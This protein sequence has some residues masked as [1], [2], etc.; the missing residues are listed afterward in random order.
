M[1]SMNWIWNAA[2]IAALTVT[3]GCGP[4]DPAAGTDQHASSNAPANAPGGQQLDEHGHPV[5]SH[6]ELDE[7]GH[8]VGTH[9]EEKP[10]SGKPG[11]PTLPGDGP[12]TKLPA[13]K[14]HATPSGLT[15]GS[16]K[17][18][19]GEAAK[20]GQMVFVHYTGWTHSTK[21]KF[22]SS[23]DRGEPIDFPLGAG[24]VIQG[25]DEGVAGMKP[26]EQRQ[27]VI[28]ADLGYGAMGRGEDIPGGATLIFD[29]EL[30][31]AQ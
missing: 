6:A 27:L 7:H 22:D 3:A 11:K 28:P 15:I 23:R 24:N 10:K 26:G 16:I 1:K 18:G 5:G 25:W 14:Y 19:K 17:D 2:A 31:K 30:V 9:A 8:P 12:W 20:A 29:V 13:A 21:K 4:Q